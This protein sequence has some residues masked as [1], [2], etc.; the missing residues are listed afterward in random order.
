MKAGG[1]VAPTWR[2]MFSE[3]PKRALK[4][5]FGYPD[6]KFRGHLI[7]MRKPKAS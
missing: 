5:R 6:G 1:G 2:A 3:Q 7:I 4:F